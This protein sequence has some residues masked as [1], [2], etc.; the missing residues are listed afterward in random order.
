[1]SLETHYK[2]GSVIGV[3]TFGKV[4]RKTKPYE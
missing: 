4:K 2:L 1:M 3:G